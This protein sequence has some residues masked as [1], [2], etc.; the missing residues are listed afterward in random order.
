M[1]GAIRALLDG[2]PSD[3]LAVLERT[4]TDGYAKALSLEAERWRIE[5]RI[6]EV[7]TT[8]RAGD[9]TAKTREIAELGQRLEASDG[10]LGL[11]R[12]LLASLRM[13]AAAARAATARATA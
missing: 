3:D 13:R 12:N 1:I 10:D 11:L 2:S 8:L 9:A 5:R 6:S 7:A 4:L